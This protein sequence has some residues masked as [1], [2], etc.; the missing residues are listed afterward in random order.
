[1]NYH[2]V[3]LSPETAGLLLTIV[4][5]IAA[6][7]VL[8][9]AVAFALFGARLSKESLADPKLAEPPAN[10]ENYRRRFEQFAELGFRPLGTS[11]ERCWFMSPIK[12]HWRSLQGNRWLGMSDN[13]T[14]VSFHRLEPDEPV[15]FGAV[16]FFDGGSLV[17]TTCPGVLGTTTEKVPGYRRVELTGVE[18]EQLLARHRQEVEAFA[19]ER[20]LTVKQMTFAEAVAAEAV[21]TRQIVGRSGQSGYSFIFNYFLVPTALAY[22]LSRPGSSLHNPAAAVCLGATVFAFFRT[23][24]FT[25][26]RRR[27]VLARHS[28]S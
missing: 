26:G 19:K 8:G 7:A 21:F 2:D 23:V 1:L 17:R 14:F 28:T 11:I 10:D 25:V 16:T 22:L 18:P 13:Q 20:S 24:V 4:A 6:G 27:R 3:V 12:F 9:P 15:R 5:A